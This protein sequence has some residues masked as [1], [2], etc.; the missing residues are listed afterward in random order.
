MRSL[1]FFES[2]VNLLTGQI[3]LEIAD[4]ANAYTTAPPISGGSG[5][6]TYTLYDTIELLDSHCLLEFDRDL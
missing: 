5:S 3:G 4:E 1:L 2:F 6:L